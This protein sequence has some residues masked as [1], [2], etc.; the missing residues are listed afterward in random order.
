M[1]VVREEEYGSEEEDDLTC[2]PCMS[3][4]VGGRRTVLGKSRGGPWAISWPGP[5]SIPRPFTFFV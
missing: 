3:V 4:S 1:N 5:D 2:G